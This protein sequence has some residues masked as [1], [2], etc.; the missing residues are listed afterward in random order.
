VAEAEAA[1]GLAAEPVELTGLGVVCGGGDLRVAVPDLR[2]T[3][4]SA[5]TAAR[6]PIA[7]NTKEIPPLTVTPSAHR[8]P[9]TGHRRCDTRAYALARGV[10]H[11]GAGGLRLRSLTS[12][13][14]G[15][16]NARGRDHS[17][18]PAGSLAC[19]RGCGQ[20]AV[21]LFYGHPRSAE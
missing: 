6:S 7:M 4:T 12:T 19:G 5:N 11:A 20:A 2:Q 15:G 9:V 8:V 10:L 13:A 1:V 21:K 18:W 17:G 14:G 16:L 3:T